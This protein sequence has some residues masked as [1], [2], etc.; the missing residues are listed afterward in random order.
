VPDETHD[1]HPRNVLER[2]KVLFNA[3]TRK[4]VLWAH[5]DAPGYMK[6][7]VGVAVSDSPCGPF[8]YLR[9]F[10]P[11][12]QESRDMTV[13]QDSNG[14]AY[15]FHS[16]EMNKTQHIV[17]LRDDFLD[18]EGDFVRAFPDELRE[19]PAVWKYRD[20]YYQI[21]SYCTGWS[22]NPARWHLAEHPLGPWRT[23]SDPC[24]G[25]DEQRATTFGSQS[26]F[27]L[28]VPGREDAFI[29]CA[30]RWKAENLQDSRYV[31]LPMWMKNGEPRIEWR[32]E[33]DFSVFDG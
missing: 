7:S 1:L 2:P 24:A 29:F 23:M 26:T 25:S 14:S 19:A 5:V 18:V 32:D 11:C 4:F 3:K 33:W 12:G 6:A 30:D 8:E 21:T 20:R 10:Q 9:C 27:V 15:L 28:P 13:W 22:A 31:W 17:K 16:S